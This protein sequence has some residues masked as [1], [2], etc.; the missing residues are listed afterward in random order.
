VGRFDR[1]PST[2]LIA[3]SFAPVQSMSLAPVPEQARS[4]PRAQ[5]GPYRTVTWKQTG[6]WKSITCIATRRSHGTRSANWSSP[7]IGRLVGTGLY[8]ELAGE[9]YAVID[10]TDGRT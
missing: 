7:I 5:G 3:L 8:D 2:R 6:F 1:L 4:V 9:V 10:G